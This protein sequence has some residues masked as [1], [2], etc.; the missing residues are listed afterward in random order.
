MQVSYPAKKTKT[1]GF[2][3]LKPTDVLF[4][5]MEKPNSLMDD[6]PHYSTNTRLGICIILGK[7]LKNPQKPKQRDML[8]TNMLLLPSLDLL[9][10]N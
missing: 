3:S 6:K 2:N 8:N 7:F 5:L 9:E 10:I 1:N 4:F